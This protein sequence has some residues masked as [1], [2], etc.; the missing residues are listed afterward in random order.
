MAHISA[1]LRLHNLGLGNSIS[2]SCESNHT[3]FAT[4]GAPFCV[5]D[6]RNTPWASV[7]TDMGTYQ[8]VTGCGCPVGKGGCPYD[9]QFNSNCSMG[10]FGGSLAW[11]RTGVRGA[12]R[13]DSSTDP[14]VIRYC[15]FE[16][17]VMNMLHGTI[18]TP[19][20]PDRWPQVRLESQPLEK[21]IARTS[22]VVRYA[23][24]IL[25]SDKRMGRVA[26][27][28]G[29]L[30]GGL[31]EKRDVDARLDPASAATVLRLSRQRRGHACCCV[32]HGRDAMP[33]SGRQLPVDVRRTPGVEDVDIDAADGLP[34]QG[35]RRCK[36]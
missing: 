31:P 5:P 11:E 28:S 12:C 25:P 26:V 23:Y 13:S 2:T 27:L 19:V 21:P 35:G 36:G 33:D 17:Q 9:P 30:A 20:Y 3:G 24:A 14:S 15:G 8:P 22:Y 29:S 34:A 18:A 4:G 6:Y 32:V 10:E 16:G 1:V 7:L